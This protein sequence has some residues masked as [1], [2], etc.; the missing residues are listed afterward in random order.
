MLTQQCFSVQLLYMHEMR[1][2]CVYRSNSLLQP[3]N[4]PAEDR[5]NVSV[6]CIANTVCLKKK[7]KKKNKPYSCLKK[8]CSS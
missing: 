2:L 8:K 3:I 1:A 5:V 4:D 6:Y 7:K